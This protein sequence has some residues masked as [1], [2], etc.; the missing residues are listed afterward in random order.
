MTSAPISSKMEPMAHVAREALQ[1]VERALAR[2]KGVLLL[3]PRQTGKTTLLGDVPKALNL[4]L[5]Q[6]GVRQR[7]ERN[8]DL[9]R[10]EVERLATRQRGSPVVVLDEVQKVPALLDVVQDLMDRRTARFV[11]CGSSARKLRRG[12]HVNLLPGRVVSVRLDPLMLREDPTRSLESRLIFGDLPGI[13]SPGRAADREEDLSSYVTT[14]LE[15]EVRAEALVRNLASFSRFL[16]LAA[17]EAGKIINLRGLSQDIGVAHTTIADYYQI[18]EDCLI[19][20]RI[21]PFTQ[22]TT[23]KK[24]TRSPRLLFFDLGVRRLAASEGRRPPRERLGDWF[25]QW[26]GLELIRMTRHWTGRCPIRFWR[27]PDGPEVDWVLDLDDRLVPIECKW[28]ESPTAKDARHLNTFLDE[29][30]SAARA[31][32]VCRTPRRYALAPRIDAV[33]WQD[34]PEIVESY[35]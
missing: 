26:V 12:S 2:G 24:L 3:G 16:E 6:A 11:L 35:L 13:V 7:Y 19:A 20:E 1:R 18:L 31:Y 9:L 15:E 10:L 33:P 34:L 21:E 22:S 14:Y 23:R 8:P 4:N 27:D 17:S 28:S 5:A 30:R 25:E 32:V 29:Y